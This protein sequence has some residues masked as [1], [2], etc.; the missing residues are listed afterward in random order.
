M[1]TARFCKLSQ[2]Q[3]QLPLRIAI[4]SYHGENSHVTTNTKTADRSLRTIIDMGK[5]VDQRPSG[6]KFVKIQVNLDFHSLD[7]IA[8]E[9]TYSYYYQLPQGDVIVQLPRG[10][11]SNGYAHNFCDTFSSPVNWWSSSVTMVH[12]ANWEHLDAT[13]PFELVSQ[14]MRGDAAGKAII[15]FSM[16]EKRFQLYSI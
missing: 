4:T 8:T 9:F 10:R 12:A 1:T 6:I 13:R 14:S 11:T 5:L 7:S 2:E 16:I 15:S 3:L